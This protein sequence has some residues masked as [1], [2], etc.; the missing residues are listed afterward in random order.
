MKA[1]LVGDNGREKTSF[2]RCWAECSHPDEPESIPDVFDGYE[3]NVKVGD[4]QV[5]LQLWDTAGQEAFPKLRPLMYVNMDIFLLLFSYEDVS[6]LESICSKWVPEI[7]QAV[8]RPLV[9]ALVGLRGNVRDNYQELEAMGES[10]F[11][12]SPVKDEMVKEVMQEIGADC[13]M[14]CCPQINYSVQ[15]MMSR[16]AAIGLEMQQKKCKGRK[17]PESIIESKGDA[18]EGGEKKHHGARKKSKCN[19]A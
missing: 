1:V 2:A 19:V 8:D 3:T 17:W 5:T 14:E 6:T 7:A 15:D 18:P 9:L 11:G 12:E 4:Q 10:P 16:V 13:F